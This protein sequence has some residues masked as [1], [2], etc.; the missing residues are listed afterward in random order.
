M[1]GFGVGVGLGGAVGTGA[2]CT[3]GSGSGVAEGSAE[4]TGWTAAGGTVETGVGDGCSIVIEGAGSFPPEAAAPA[5]LPQAQKRRAAVSRNGILLRSLNFISF[6]Q[7][8][9]IVLY[10]TLKGRFG[11]GE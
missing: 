5:S 3:V 6:P 1:E 7:I 4:G 10:I 8:R 2:S 9:V 11:Q